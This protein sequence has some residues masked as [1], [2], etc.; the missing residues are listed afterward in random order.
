MA[1]ARN[2]A[3]KAP[4]GYGDGPHWGRGLGMLPPQ[5]M[6]ELKLWCILG[7]NFIAGEL[8]VLHA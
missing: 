5:K 4:R 3:P 2:E 1:S 6:F 7:A 8:P